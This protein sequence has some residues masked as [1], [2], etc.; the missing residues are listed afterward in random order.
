MLNSKFTSAETNAI[1]ST[2]KALANFRTNQGKGKEKKKCIQSCN[3]KSSAFLSEAGTL[4][5]AIPVVIM[6]MLVAEPA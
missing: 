1:S 2:Q 3:P 6:S 5:L 4:G